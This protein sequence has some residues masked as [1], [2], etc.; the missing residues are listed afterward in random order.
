MEMSPL[1]STTMAGNS[2]GSIDIFM[3]LMNGPLY[4]TVVERAFAII[5]LIA[6]LFFCLSGKSVGE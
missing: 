2:S 1:N 4:Y 3:L 5:G 6:M